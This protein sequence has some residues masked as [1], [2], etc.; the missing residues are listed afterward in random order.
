VGLAVETDVPKYI[1][2][3]CGTPGYVAPEILNLVNKEDKYGTKC[4][5]FS[6]GCIF[7]KL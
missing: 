6:C 4:D 3:K 5:I 2:P 7:Y 1:F